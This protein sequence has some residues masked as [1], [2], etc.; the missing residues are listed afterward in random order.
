MG[1]NV[2]KEKSFS[3]AIRITKL[4]RFLIEEKNEYVLSKQ[5]LRSGTSIGAMVREAEFSESKSDFVHK[6]AIAQKETNETIYWIDL[7]ASVN[8]IDENLKESLQTDA[9]ELMKI[10]TASIK[11]AK[12]SLNIKH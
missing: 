6:M 5:I 9:T 1:A 2:L 7:L 8:Y 12:N 3:F 11:T 10:I 4:N